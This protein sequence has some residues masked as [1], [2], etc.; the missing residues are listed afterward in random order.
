MSKKIY[1]FLIFL[2]LAGLGYAGLV[3]N[4]MI[5]SN[6]DMIQT[7]EEEDGAPTVPVATI[8]KVPNSTL[9]DNADGTASLSFGVIT[10]VDPTALLTAGTDNVKDT[11]IDFGTG[12]TQVSAGDLPIADAGTI[13]T[14]TEVEGA[15]Q[16]NRTAIDL[17]TIHSTDNTQAHTDY[18]INNGN[19]TTSGIL[20]SAGI[21]VGDGQ[22]VGATT[23]KWLFDDTNGDISTTGNVG[24]GTTGPGDKLHIEGT[25]TTTYAS[26]MGSYNPEAHGLLIENQFTTGANAYS[27]IRFLAGDTGSA[28]MS[29]FKIGRA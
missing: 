27:G 8:I 7:I 20:T 1:S 12:A 21:I 9:T 23:N 14:A 6:M 3:Y 25:D 24:I 29:G 17:N 28:L 2:S 22:T 4:P 15:L 11:H 5:H 10:E 19:D 18:L 13:I 26:D 16:E